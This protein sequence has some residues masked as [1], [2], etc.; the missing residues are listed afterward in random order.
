MVNDIHLTSWEN[1]IL[2]S[3]LRDILDAA[4]NAPCYEKVFR[5]P[6]YEK[7]FRLK[8]SICFDDETEDTLRTILE[9]L[10]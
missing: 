6:C 10:G 4:D 2:D 5:L 8:C 7:V 9:K 1:A 3:V